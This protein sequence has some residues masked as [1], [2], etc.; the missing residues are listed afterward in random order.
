MLGFGFQL[1]SHVYTYT[2]DY[3]RTQLQLESDLPVRDYRVSRGKCLYF[4]N[5]MVETLFSRIN[6]S[7]FSIMQ[8]SKTNDLHSCRQ[9]V[10]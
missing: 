2:F 6:I 4:L 10:I 5:E 9:N 8:E 1:E 7:I 3:L